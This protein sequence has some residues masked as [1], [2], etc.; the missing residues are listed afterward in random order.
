MCDSSLNF[1]IVSD[2]EKSGNGFG[3]RARSD[4][5]WGHFSSEHMDYG[6]NRANFLRKDYY[7]KEYL[8]YFWH[9]SDQHG[10]L[11]NMLNVLSKDVAVD[12]DGNLFLNTAAVQHRRKRTLEQEEDED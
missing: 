4:T 7:N 9:M 8:L 11:S 10:I 1:Q 3:Q 12:C 2:W 5:S 6:D